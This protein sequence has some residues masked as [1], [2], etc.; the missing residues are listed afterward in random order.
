M[1]TEDKILVEKYLYGD[2]E[3]FEILMQRHLKPIFN[4][5][6]RLSRN[7]QAAED[8]SQDTFIKVWKNLHK[9][10]PERGYL[11]ASQDT[12]GEK[13][14]SY[15]TAGSGSGFKTWLF[16]IAKNTAFDYLKKKKDLP[17]AAFREEEDSDGFE[18]IKA[19]ET[20]ADEV[21]ERKDLAREISAK[22]GEIPD[23]YRI[24][25]V[26]HYKEDFSLHEISEILGKP[27]NTIKS[28][29]RRAILRLKIALK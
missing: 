3:S 9:F 24:I 14:A 2:E 15:R 12:Q 5:A 18:N 7:R 22:I 13:P 8:I 29:H 28:Y 21:L 27:Y 1:T 20:L 26:L 19:E 10:D 25:L 11:K 4:F 23:P 16:A 17:F 6:Y